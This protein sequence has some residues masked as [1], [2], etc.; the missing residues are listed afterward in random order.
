MPPTHLSGPARALYR[1]FIQPS[2]HAS[3]APLPTPLRA[4]PS[5]LQPSLLPLSSR[6]HKSYAK[7]TTRQS[8]TDIFIT[9][10]AIRSPYI[11]L[12]DATGFHPAVPLRQVLR[13]FDRALYH[14]IQV[15]PGSAPPDPNSGA[16]PG[17]DNHAALPTCKLVSKQELREQQRAKLALKNKAR[18]R[19]GAGTAGAKQL[20]VNWAIGP[21]DLR[22]RLVRLKEFLGQ[23]RKVEVLLAP[24]KQ[25]RRATALEAQ[26]VVARVRE[27][28]GEC[29]GAVEVRE[30]EGK[31]GGVFAMVF[32]GKVV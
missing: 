2:L 3:R 12:V 25:G 18:S 7:D 23:G 1:V 10:E 8:L 19:G 32:E 9:D 5:P 13:S 6:R 15:A 16:A 20:E 30:P 31:V 24:R 4:A 28:V 29:E 14:L 26:A 17:P 11:N 21:N 27:A 22:H